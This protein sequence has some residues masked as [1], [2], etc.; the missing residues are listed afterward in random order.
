[1]W[2]F[3]CQPITCWSSPEGEHPEKRELQ[4]DWEYHTLSAAHWEY[5]ALSVRARLAADLQGTLVRGQRW[6]LPSSWGLL[7]P[8]MPTAYLL[9]LSGMLPSLPYSSSSSL[10]PSARSLSLPCSPNVLARSRG[11]SHPPSITPACFWLVVAWQ[12]I[13]RRPSKDFVVFYFFNFFCHSIHHSE[14]RKT[15]PPIHSTPAAH[16]LHHPSYRWRQLSV[17]C[18]VLR[19]NSGYLRPRTHPPLYFSMF[20]YLAS[21]PREPAVARANPPPGACNRLVGS[22]GTMIWGHGRWCHGDKGQSCWG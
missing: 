17:E 19:P 7:T 11:L 2:C 1:M 16:P 15:T 5:D 6:L 14:I 20:L 8:L 3:V 9:L 4:M 21:Q 12:N 13:E 18:C 22:R 10:L